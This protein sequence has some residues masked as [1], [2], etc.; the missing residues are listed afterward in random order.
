MKTLYQFRKECRFFAVSQ[1][2]GL[3]SEYPGNTLRL[4]Q[5]FKRIKI[6]IRRILTLR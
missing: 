4:V 2:S 5:L 6:S 1:V 3:T